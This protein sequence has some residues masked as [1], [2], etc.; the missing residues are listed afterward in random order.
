M[1]LADELVLVD[2]EQPVEDD[3]RRNGR[4]A[5]ADGADLFGFDERDFDE[6]VQLF[7]QG[8][9]RDPAGGSA[10]CDHHAFDRPPH[11]AVE[12]LQ[13]VGAQ[14]PGARVI[15]RRKDSARMLGE[16]LGRARAI[17]KHIIIE[18][19]LPRSLLL[20]RAIAPKD[21]KKYAP[22]SSRAR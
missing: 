3:N 10:P 12:P 21:V 19:C 7:R 5:D 15:Q 22:D 16:V 8:V 14:P 9:S 17:A 18:Q 6:R 4:F 13:Q 20:L 11:S 1:G 2:A